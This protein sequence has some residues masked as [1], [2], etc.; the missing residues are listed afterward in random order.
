MMD[1]KERGA[2]LE[3]M[4]EASNA[5]YRAAVAIGNHPFIEFTGVINEYINA[6]RAAHAKG[7]DFSDCSTH[8]GVELPMESFQVKYINEKLECIFQ[9]LSVAGARS[10]SG[11]ESTRE[12]SAESPERMTAR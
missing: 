1:A 4:A 10:P 11:M 7:I 5:F 3:K 12:Q 8:S 6:C 9:G 2:A